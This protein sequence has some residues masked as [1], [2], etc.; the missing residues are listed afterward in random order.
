[1]NKNE[2]NTEFPPEEEKLTMSMLTKEKAESSQFYTEEAPKKSSTYNRLQKDLN[3]LQAK[4]KGLENKLKPKS[5]PR[6]KDLEDS[7]EESQP[8]ESLQKERSYEF[9]DVKAM[10]FNNEKNDSQENMQSTLSLNNTKY[11]HNSK[12]KSYMRPTESSKKR[13]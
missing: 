1:M 2:D 12:K 7:I 3:S 4:I 11:T 5:K 8:F 13:S 6:K 10:T 9:S